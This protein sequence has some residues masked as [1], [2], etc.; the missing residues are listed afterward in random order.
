MIIFLIHLFFFSWRIES[1]VAL[2]HD[3]HLSKCEIDYNADT[4]SLEMSLSI[5]LD[6]LELALKQEGFEQLGLCTSRESLEA[7]GIVFDY[8]KRHITVTV[9]G[10]VYDNF[11]WVGKEVSDDLA[12][13]WCYIEVLD[14]KRPI[15]S[16]DVRYDALMEI[17]DDQQN[18]VKLSLPTNK[19]AYFLLTTRDRTGSMRL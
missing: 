16:L 14:V 5:F 3:F 8:L 2:E 15:S 19:K 18:V 12:A 11:H 6:D 7:E 13:V 4:R 17:F 9:D 10:Q 1:S